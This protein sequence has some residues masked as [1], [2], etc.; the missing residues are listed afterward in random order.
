M[1][2]S[3]IYMMLLDSLL[4]KKQEHICRC[5]LVFWLLVLGTP[6]AFLRPLRGTQGTRTTTLLLRRVLVLGIQFGNKKIDIAK[7]ISIFLAPRVG[8]EPTTYR[9]TAERSTS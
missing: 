8:L 5:V 2:I 4:N 3:H 7:A 9:L 6:G 1:N